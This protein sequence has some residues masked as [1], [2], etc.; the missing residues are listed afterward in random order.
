MNVL[1]LNK[2]TQIL[3]MLVEG[4]SMRSITRVVGVSMNAV[5][6]LLRDAG[7]ACEA[8]HDEHVR[9]VP[10][11]LVQCDEIW[12]FCYAKE[13][14]VD[15]C[16]DPPE[17]AGD[18]WT[19]TAIDDSSRLILAWAVS[20]DRSPEYALEFMDDLRGRLANRVQLSTDGWGSYIPAVE[21][22]FG[23]DVD[24]AQV[25]KTYG[26]GEE[27]GEVI[28][29][30]KIPVS[31]DPDLWLAETAYVERHNLTTRMSMRR[32]TR[33]T[34]AHSKRI[35]RH[36]QALALYFTWYN[37][38]RVH[39]TLKQ[40]PAMEAGLAEY[41]YSLKWLVDLIDARKPLPGPRGPYK[42]RAR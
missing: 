5:V 32:F 30:T 4:S 24:Y 38:C 42:P 39:S 13:R 34:N 18:V 1:P 41:P 15:E 26:T 11:Q 10:A 7:E 6:R 9:E 3:H 22:A 25:I 19:W 16:V 35:Y 29:V 37:F 23:G 21:G 12:A 31:G 2:R 33:L 40:T 27:R 17:G 20:P 8:Y 28:D 36:C 14:N